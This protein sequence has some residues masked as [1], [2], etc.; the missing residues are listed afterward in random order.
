[1]KARAATWL[2][3]ALALAI[4]GSS[5]PA[6]AQV[7]RSSFDP[8]YFATDSAELRGAAADAIAAAAAWIADHPDGRLVVEGHADRRGAAAYNQ[9]LSRQRAEAVRDALVAA[10][11]PVG[12]IAIVA[13]GEAEPVSRVPAQN[14]RV[15]IWATT[16]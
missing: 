5:A 3:P 8:I 15:R 13:S 9:A 12:K 10:G 16:F 4:A 6:A 1:M 11:V 14:R 7:V 2:G